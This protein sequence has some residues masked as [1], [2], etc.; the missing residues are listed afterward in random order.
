MER[1]ANNIV[2][3]MKTADLI[4]EDEIEIYRYLGKNSLFEKWVDTRF[5]PEKY[6]FVPDLLK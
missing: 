4:S 2:A 1:F 5:V 6:G 3:K